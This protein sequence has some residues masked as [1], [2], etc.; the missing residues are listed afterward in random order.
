MST[1]S[2]LIDPRPYG[3][4]CIVWPQFWN[5]TSPSYT[6]VI[7]GSR[8]LKEHTYQVLYPVHGGNVLFRTVEYPVR[9]LNVAEHERRRRLPALEVAGKLEP[10]PVPP[11]VGTEEKLGELLVEKGL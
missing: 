4:S 5:I 2:T 3:P 6:D 11:A 7:C 1:D 10:R 9:E 8:T